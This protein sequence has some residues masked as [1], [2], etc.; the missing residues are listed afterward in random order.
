MKSVTHGARVPFYEYFKPR[1]TQIV[2]LLRLAMEGNLTSRI[3]T[4][5]FVCLVQLFSLF[6]LFPLLAS[7]P[8]RITFVTLLTESSPSPIRFVL[9]DASAVE[10]RGFVDRSARNAEERFIA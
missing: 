10:A 6:S 1:L 3:G 4:S 5:R 8:A 7:S 2:L 9:A